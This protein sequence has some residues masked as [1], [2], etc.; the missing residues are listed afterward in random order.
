MEK[1]QAFLDERLEPGLE[2]H[3]S[4]VE[5][6]G[7]LFRQLADLIRDEIA[8]AK[9]EV[10]DRVRVYRVAASIAGAGLVL[11]LLASMALIAAVI[12]ALAPYTGWALS[13]LIVGGVLGFVSMILIFWGMRQF[14]RKE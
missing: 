5:L 1:R 10:H 3:P 12:I 13:S 7:S 6:L 11:G 9:A 2:P 8:L 4:F 14:G